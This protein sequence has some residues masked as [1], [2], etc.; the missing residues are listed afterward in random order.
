MPLSPRLHRAVDAL[1]MWVE[2]RP[3]RPPQGFRPGPG[4]PL[5]AFGPV[6]PAP[7]PAPVPPV[8]RFAVPA[9]G[10]PPGDRALVR[11]YPARGRPRGTAV[12]V[13]PWKTPPAAALRGWTGLLSRLGLE[14]WLL[15]PPH[16]RGRTAP[17]GR[18]GEAFVSN[19]LGRLRASLAETVREIRMLA[20]AAAPRG[21]VGLLGL[22]LGA[23]AAAHAATAP[24]P[25]AFAALVAPPADLAQVFAATPIGARY[26]RL[27]ERA[28]APLPPEAELRAL[29]EPLS[30]AG[31]RPTAARVLVAAGTHDAIVPPQGPTALARAWGLE[32][33][34][35]PRGHL[36][37]L[38]ACRA[39]RREVGDL[40]RR[41]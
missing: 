1:A 15:V 14:V 3:A 9:W 25:L 29:L 20:A 18:S 6:P 22:S 33:R 30:P 39:L 40:A 35:F 36:T 37:L 4:G 26:R 11:A 17:G 24:E 8:W 27:A 10:G 19:D 2:D 34:L 13:P 41:G 12:L 32:P 23:L 5:D 28:G 38:F 31:R 7:A 21:P 16:H